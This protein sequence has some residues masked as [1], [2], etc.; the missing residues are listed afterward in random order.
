LTKSRRTPQ[1]GLEDRDDPCLEVP[2][3][4]LSLAGTIL[5]RRSSVTAWRAEAKGAGRPGNLSV[6]LAVLSEEC[7]Y[8]DESRTMNLSM[9]WIRYAIVAGLFFFGAV[10]AG[11]SG[12]L[13]DP[14]V[15]SSWKRPLVL[16][17][18]QAGENSK[19]RRVFAV[20]P[21]VSKIRV[22]GLLEEGAWAKACLIPLIYEWTPGENIP[23]P[24]KTDCLVTYDRDYFYVAFRAYDP[25]PSRIRAHLMDRDAVDTLIQDDHVSVLLD[26]FNDERRGFQFRVNPLGVQADAIFSEL[27]GYED[28]SWDAIWNSA[29]RI[30]DWGYAVEMSIPFNQLR[31]PSTDKPMT[32][33][34]YAERSYPRNVRYRISSS[35]R[36]RNVA[37]LLCQFN[38]ITGIEGVTPGKNLEIDPTLT[39]TRTDARPDFPGGPMEDGRAKMKPGLTARWGITSNL[40]LNGTVNPDFS[41]VEADVAQLDVNTRFALYYPEKRPFFLEG[42]DFFLT[43]FQAVFTR[44]VADP[45]GGIKLTGKLG[46]N[47]LGFFGASDRINNLLIPSNQG[48][49]QTSLE[50]DVTSAVFRYRR[51]VG[52]GS[53]LGALYTG[54]VA[55]DYYNHLAG[56]DGFFRLSQTKILRFQYLHTETRYPDEVVAGFGQPEGGFGGDAFQADLQHAGRDWYW[57]INY[58]DLSPKFRADYGYIPRVDIRR[59]EAALQRILWGKPGGWYT[60]MAF[61][62]GG[63]VVYDHRGNL[64][65]QEVLLAAAYRGSYQ[66]TAQ[67]MLSQNKELYRAVLYDLTRAVFFGEIKPASGLLFNLTG[68]FG[69]SVDYQNAREADDLIL[70][71]GTE[72]GIGRHININFSHVLER[73]SLHGKEIFTAN[74]PQLRLI[75]NFSVRAYIRGIFQYLNVHRN[76]ALYV[77]PVPARTSTFFTQLLF[78]YKLN[79][80]TVLFLGYS[81]NYLGAR[82]I[83]LTQTDRTFFVKVGYAWTD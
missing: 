1:S 58:R 15:S 35:R 53:T 4:G 32:W 45:A 77:F 65:D 11:T 7:F 41:Q 74:L 39:A 47:A 73:L 50:E 43:P 51:D 26:T 33:G 23:P 60:Q 5:R 62:L 3:L 42:A 82:G 76:Q 18:Q 61:G 52:V 8:P 63:T 38:K 30:T 71:P 83:D 70:S 19:A 48:S 68:Q 34:F 36:E 16:C 81:D 67:L 75:Y 66:S 69:D 80:R 6:T 28:F 56:V 27:E 57:D 9:S 12:A 40:I 25:D 24:V 21:A 55:G 29:G 13:A 46:P 20:T 2:G 37:C 49:S 78:S 14:A 64:T 54:R 79:P 59:G 10:L 72:F 44:T 17:P 22:D 31:F